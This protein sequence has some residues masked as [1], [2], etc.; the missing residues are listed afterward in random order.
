M[1]IMKRKPYQTVLIYVGLIAV[2]VFFLGPIIW[3]WALSLRSPT[4]A[5]AQPPQLI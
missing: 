3:F 4:S 1:V 2:M 5:F